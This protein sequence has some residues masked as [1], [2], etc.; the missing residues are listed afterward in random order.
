MNCRCSD[1]GCTVSAPEQEELQGIYEKIGVTYAGEQ[2]GGCVKRNKH[3]EDTKGKAG[4][5][6]NIPCQQHPERANKVRSSSG[7]I[8]RFQMHVVTLNGLGVPHSLDLVTVMTASTGMVA[9]KKLL[10][11]GVTIPTGMPVL[12][13]ATS[14]ATLSCWQL[15]LALANTQA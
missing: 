10:S 5:L 2:D 1:T 9:L 11:W 15:L 3:T 6:Q 8:L 4:H 7:V 14:S 12:S 13:V